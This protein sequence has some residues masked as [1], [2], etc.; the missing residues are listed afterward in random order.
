MQK[1]IKDQK[2]K[3]WKRNAIGFVGPGV[4]NPIC[5]EGLIIKND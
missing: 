1:R 5:S 4:A 3:N 2:E